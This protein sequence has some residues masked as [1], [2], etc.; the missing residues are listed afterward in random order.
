MKIRF[1]TTSKERNEEEQL[2]RLVT[3]VKKRYLHFQYTYTFSALGHS[4]NSISLDLFFVEGS[5]TRY[6]TYVDVVLVSYVKSITAVPQKK[7]IKFPATSSG[8]RP[9]SS[10]SKGQ[11]NPVESTNLRLVLCKIYYNVWDYRVSLFHFPYGQNHKEDRSISPAPF[12][13][14]PT[15]SGPSD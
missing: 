6:M 7:A 8:S 9:T 11:S 10:S 3:K 15:P 12:P 1:N 5:K 4:L 2:V 13:P 14:H